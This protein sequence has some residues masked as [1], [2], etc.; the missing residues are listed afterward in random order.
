[1]NLDFLSDYMIPVI[2]GICLC[3]GYIIKSWEKV[4]NKWIPTILTVIGLAIAMWIH[5]W[6]ATPD[7]ILKGLASGLASCGLYD[8]FKHFFIDGGDK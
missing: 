5:R 2:V 3:V 7:I 6:S 4:P 1:M 8:T